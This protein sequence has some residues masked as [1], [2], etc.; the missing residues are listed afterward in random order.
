MK[1]NGIR[2]DVHRRKYIPDYA[3]LHPGYQLMKHGRGTR[4]NKAVDT[5]I[6]LSIDS[7]AS[8]YLKEIKTI[9]SQA[10]QHIH[11]DI[12]ASQVRQYL[13]RGVT[14]A[15]A[16]VQC[17]QSRLRVSNKSLLFAMQEIEQHELLNVLCA[18]ARTIPDLSDR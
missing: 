17:L 14:P 16:G 12:T 1:C 6:T 18:S 11:R 13:H 9:L 3:S 5:G 4:N 2:G 15:E 10:S 7:T 8:S